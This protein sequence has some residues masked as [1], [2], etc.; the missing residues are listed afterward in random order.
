VGRAAAF[1][2]IRQVTMKWIR[3][4]ALLLFVIVV[5]RCGSWFLGWQFI[6]CMP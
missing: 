4:A 5:M 2:E 1:R 6:S 3:I